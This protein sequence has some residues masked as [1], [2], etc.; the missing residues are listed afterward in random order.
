MA[1]PSDVREMAISIPNLSNRLEGLTHRLWRKWIIARAVKLVDEGTIPRPDV[2]HAHVVRP[3]GAAATA[4]AGK[5]Q[6]KVVLTEHSNPFSVHLGTAALRRATHATLRQFD[7]VVAV[8]PFLAGEIRSAFAD[9]TPEIVGNV[10]DETFFCPGPA[11]HARAPGQPLRFLFVGGLVWYKGVDVLL[12]ASAR[13]L[14]QGLRNWQLVI[15]GDG[16]HRSRLEKQI[17][18]LGLEPNIKMVGSQPREVVRAWMRSA[19]ALVQP[20]RT[21]TFCVV[22]IEAIACGIPVITT[23]CGG[24]AWIVRPENGQIVPVGDSE[25]LANA[26]ARRSQGRTAFDPLLMRSSIISRFGRIAWLGE[27]EK[28]YA[29]L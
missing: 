11:E 14:D 17:A 3:A 27:I 25:A 8:S 24:P 26:M 2:V 22:L 18:V 15:V 20:S 7:S 19:D 5:W 13:L 29:G 6:T 23:D 12:A 9:L 21:E 10:V 1:D 28:I 4:L 16:P